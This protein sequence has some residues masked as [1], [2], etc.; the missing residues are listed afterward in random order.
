MTTA[1]IKAEIARLEARINRARR[2]YPLMWH[3]LCSEEKKDLKA[4]RA[5]LK[6]SKD[7]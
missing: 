2:D 3:Y 4:L 1:E 5:K 7:G 6:R